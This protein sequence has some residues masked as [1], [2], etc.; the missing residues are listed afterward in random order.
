MTDGSTSPKNPIWPAWPFWPLPL[1][2]SFAST[3]PGELVQPINPGWTF[4]NLISVTEQNSS[5]PDT[6]RDIV[7]ADSYGRQLGR[8]MDA[9]VELISEQPESARQKPA[10]KELIALHQRIQKIKSR[11]AARRVDRIAA[12]LADLR[13]HNPEEYRRVS[14]TLRETLGKGPTGEPE[15][16]QSSAS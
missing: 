15:P 2:T 6:E 11:A 16:K 8:V 9:L 3:A 7:A 13:E 14:A 5:A 10:F 1:P 12:D 4:G